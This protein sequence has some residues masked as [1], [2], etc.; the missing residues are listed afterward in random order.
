[1]GR[2]RLSWLSRRSLVAVLLACA[3]LVSLV[4]FPA[5]VPSAAQRSCGGGACGC[6][7]HADRQSST[8]CCSKPSK[9]IRFAPVESC[10]AKP[11]AKSCCAKPKPEVIWVV[12]LFAKSCKGKSTGSWIAA[13]PAVPPSEPSAVPFPPDSMP[14]LVARFAPPPA[15][16]SVPPDPPPRFSV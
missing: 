9:T 13:E 7:T 5:V 1:M 3:Q 16:P 2:P 8:C 10:C 6:R 4:G 14:V 12:G 15:L 11:G